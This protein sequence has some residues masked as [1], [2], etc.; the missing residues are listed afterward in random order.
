M[1]LGGW[2]SGWS[3]E[4]I[5]ELFDGGEFVGV[6]ETGSVPEKDAGSHSSSWEDFISGVFSL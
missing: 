6:L 4:G 2:S 1:H 3:S 5:L